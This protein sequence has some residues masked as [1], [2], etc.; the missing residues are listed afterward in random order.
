MKKI[1]HQLRDHSV[2]KSASCFFGLAT[3]LL[4][5][6]PA[7]PALAEVTFRVAVPED[8]DPGATVYIA[9]DFQSW[10]P[11]HADSKLNR[12]QD[13]VWE[14]VLPLEAGKAIQFKF[15]LG[16]WERVEK[17]PEGQEIQNRLY[18]VEGG[19]TVNL[20]VSNWAQGESRPSSLTGHIE[21]ITIPGF[22]DD[23]KIWVY[24]PPGYEADDARRYPVLYMMDG[25][26]V[27]DDATSFAG[28]WKVDE[29]L[30]ELISAGRVAPLIVVAVANG[31]DRR[32]KEYTPWYSADRQAGGGGG[33]HLESWVEMLLP[34]IDVHYRTLTGPM[35][36]GLAGSSFGGLMTLFGAY[37][38]AD[39]FGKFGSFS[40]SLMWAGGRLA[41][42]IVKNDKPSITIYMDMGT[43][44]VGNLQDKDGN[45]IDDNIDSLR[46]M[47]GILLDQGFVEG[48]DLMVVEGDGH[49]H[50]EAYWA[51]RFPAAVE[52]LF[53]V[54]P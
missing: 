4:F 27:F 12:I 29:T 15:T 13:G 34:Y 41:D 35:N 52:F 42:M 44:E 23:R 36:T 25:Q 32:T 33:K 46:S 7:I 14:I 45:G 16:G 54:N 31:G 48:W 2:M 1:Q 24:L 38:H 28:E 53:P 47:R 26:N 11:G 17:G 51:Q 5:S 19:E 21:I 3:I 50:N 20:K 39:V 6:L 9:G 22:H 40:P 43:R 8:T 10:Q 37:T 18:K 49:R 30:E